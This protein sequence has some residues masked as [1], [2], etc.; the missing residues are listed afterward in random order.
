MSIRAATPYLILR[1][2]AERAIALYSRVLGARTETLQRFGEVDQSC[3]AARRELVMHA[4]LRIGNALLMLS[5]GP[6]EGA[7]PAGRTA[8]CVALDFDGEAELRRAF[9]GLV[10]N[11]KPIMPVFDAA[12][13]RGI[14]RGGGRAR[15]PLDA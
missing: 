10:A 9:D 6:E 14:R 11:G 1:G 2:H 15:H 12:V 3:P 4:S 8:V 13:E 7:L 5:D